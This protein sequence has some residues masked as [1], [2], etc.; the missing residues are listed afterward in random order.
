[1]NRNVI[2]EYIDVLQYY[3]EFYG[4]YNID[5]KNLL[6]TST[7]IVQDIKKGKN[8]P[9][10]KKLD[11]IAQLFG[12]NYYEFGN[13]DFKLPKKENLP[14]PTLEKILWRDEVGP[15]ESK[16]Y[17]KLDLNNAVVDAL[18]AFKDIEKFL[19]SEVYD[20]LS[21]ELKE[22]LNSA[23]RITGLF[24]DELKENVEKTGEKLDKKGVGRKQE[25]YRVI[26]L[27]KA[28]KDRK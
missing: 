25:Y 27:K 16:K 1:M 26:S 12:L 7:D 8:G 23:I 13:P 15:P 22:K 11:A 2:D 28:S 5:I 18:T 19:P 20:S 24:S 9:T 10:L 6:N 21:Q 17:N 3:L 14:R 4:L